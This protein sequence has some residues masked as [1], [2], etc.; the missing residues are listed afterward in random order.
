MAPM[1][2]TA[3][4]R[5]DISVTSCSSEQFVNNLSEQMATF[6]DQG[7]STA[8]AS[9]TLCVAVDISLKAHKPEEAAIFFSRVQKHT[10]L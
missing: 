8:P 4:R 10:A 1:K 6:A 3:L 7:D 5:G 9:P 2:T